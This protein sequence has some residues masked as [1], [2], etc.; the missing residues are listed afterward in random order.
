MSVLTN[1]LRSKIFYVINFVSNVDVDGFLQN[2]NTELFNWRDSS[3]KDK[4][5]GHIW[6]GDLR[7]VKNSKLRELIYKEPKFR[8]KNPINFMKPRKYLKRRR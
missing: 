2:P 4:D 8:E 1:T 5:H 3:F 6:K 7:F